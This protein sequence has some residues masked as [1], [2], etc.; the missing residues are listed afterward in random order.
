MWCRN[1]PVLLDTTV[2]RHAGV[3]GAGGAGFPTYAKLQGRAEVVVANG[4]EC[5][6]LLRVDQ[7]LMIHRATDVVH[8]LEVAASL[9]G[10]DEMLV[11]VKKKHR[12]AIAAMEA[13]GASVFPLPDFYPVGDEHVLVYESTRRVVPQGGLPLDVGVVTQNIET[14]ANIAAAADGQPV[15]D[16]YVSVLGEVHNGRELRLPVGMLVRDVI[17]LCGGARVE[18][19]TVIDGG[20]MMGALVEADDP[21]TKTTKALLVLSQEHPLVRMKLSATAPSPRAMKITQS[22]CCACRICTDLCP[23]YLLGHAIA[24]D[25]AVGNLHMAKGDEA[26]L[27]SAALCTQCN[28]CGYFACPLRLQPNEVHANVKRMIKELSLPAHR[29]SGDRTE[30]VVFRD[31]RRVP[32]HR[33]IQRLWLDRYERDLRW[34]DSGHDPGEVRLRMHQHIGAPASPIVKVGARVGRGDV[35]GVVGPDELGV[36]V[37]ASI[38][39][40]VAAVDETAVV[41]TA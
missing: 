14:L 12:A 23:R 4:A 38:D 26:L 36:P 1:V 34:D 19:Y 17:D 9:V 15:V 35:V 30:P 11:G 33:L 18:P 8:G 24:P 20:P 3:V 16:T 29:P 31:W 28:L 22:A 41:I 2:I 25:R 6:P 39:G 32:S 7:G 21:I 27:E 37:H 5:E 13:A 10:A 40:T